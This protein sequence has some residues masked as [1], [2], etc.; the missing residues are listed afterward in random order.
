M[1]APTSK[2]LAGHAFK[3]LHLVSTK[4]QPTTLSTQ[5]QKTLRIHGA[6]LWISFSRNCGYILANRCRFAPQCIS[7]PIALFFTLVFFL[8][9]L[10][11][12]VLSFLL[13]TSIS[14][15][16]FRNDRVKPTFIP[17]YNGPFKVLEPNEKSL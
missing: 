11:Q 9:L 16:F 5:V 6:L 12:V 7:K 14:K 15:L 17:A 10:F 4:L 1:V 3:V 8:S 2:N 13:F